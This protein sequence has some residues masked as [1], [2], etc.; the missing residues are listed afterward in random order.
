MYPGK[1]DTIVA[2]L[3]CLQCKLVWLVVP[4]QWWRLPWAKP[5]FTE[6]FV[7]WPVMNKLYDEIHQNVLVGC[8]VMLTS[9]LNML[10][11]L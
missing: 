4:K 6:I 9:T 10:E 1:L 5:R 11:Q 3:F 7:L 2:E 8:S